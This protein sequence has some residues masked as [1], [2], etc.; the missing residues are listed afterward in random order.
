V[1]Q[2]LR[3]KRIYDADRQALVYV[4]FSTRL[5]TPSVG[6]LLGLGFKV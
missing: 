6:A 5:S 1:P 4:A 2:T 3:V